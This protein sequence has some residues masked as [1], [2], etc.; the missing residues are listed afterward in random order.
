MSQLQQVLAAAATAPGNQANFQAAGLIAVEP[1]SNKIQLAPDWQAAFLRLKLIDRDTV[2]RHPEQYLATA[3]DIVYRGVTSGS[4]GQHLTYFAGAT[5]NEMRVQARQRSLAWWGIDERTPIVN[6]ASR[7]QPVRAIDQTIVGQLT[8]AWIEQLLALMV[9]SVVLRGYPSR[10]CDVATCLMDRSLPPVLA[11]I[12]TGECLFNFQKAL[13]EN[14]FRAPIINEYG[15]QET[16]ISG[17]TCPEAGRLHLDSDRCLYETI[18]NQLVTTDLYNLAMPMVRYRCGDIAELSSDRCPCGHPGLAARILG[19]IEDRIQ[20]RSGKKYAGEIVMPALEGIHTYQVIRQNTQLAIRVQSPS[21]CPSLE[22]LSNWA[23]DTFGIVETQ[24]VIDHDQ[25]QSPEVQT[26][27]NK[28]WIAGITTDSWSNWLAQSLLPTGGLRTAAQL[29]QAL[30][31]PNIVTGAGLPS[32]TQTLLQIVLDRTLTGDRQIDWITARILLFASSSLTDSTQILPIYH[33]AAEQLQQ[34][35]RSS[36]SL[37]DLLIP[38]LFLETDTALAIW[39][40]HRD[41]IQSVD[42]QLLPIDRFHIHALLQAF[43]PAAQHATRRSHLHLLRP[44]LS[45]LIGDLSLFASRFGIWLLAHWFELL[46][47]STLNLE[48]IV[49]VPDEFAD[50]WLTWRR[51][52]IRRHS[53]MFDTLAT[54][55]IVAQTPAE[56]VRVELE[57]G[58]G[59]LMMERSLE[60]QQWVEILRSQVKVLGSSHSV[61]PTA[62]APILKALAPSLLAEGQAKLA[63]ECLLLSTIPTSR[64]SAFERMAAQCNQKQTVICDLSMANLC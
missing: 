36:Q 22:P 53:S 2:R 43:E 46:H 61:D 18:D 21:D 45:I 26:C 5:W 16:G 37:I 25:L 8:P 52:L 59:T 62:W 12:C 3:T 11:V 41:R 20:T 4:R 49:H 60:S 39:A 27:N 33:Q 40:Q 7:L 29:L 51:H 58:Y 28:D 42:N 9:Q 44:L 24:V 56:Q 35:D 10:L 15:C 19:R 17:L 14:V 13:L 47:N 23:I 32:L 63:Y 57:H 6:V 54:L 30:V 1:Q 34:V 38:T 64:I 48:A 55:R 50:A 31:S